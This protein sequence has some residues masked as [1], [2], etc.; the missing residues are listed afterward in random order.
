MEFS[1]IGNCPTGQLDANTTEGASSLGT[2][3]PIRVSVSHGNVSIMLWAAIKKEILGVT[4]DGWERSSRQVVLCACAPKIDPVMSCDI[5]VSDGVF[6][7]VVVVF[8]WSR[9][10]L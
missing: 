7:T 1:F 2:S 8:S 9:V 5:K 10:G 6:Q 3:C 4:V